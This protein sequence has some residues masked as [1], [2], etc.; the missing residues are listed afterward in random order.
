MANAFLTEVNVNVESEFKPPAHTGVKLQ[1]PGRGEK[2]LIF[3]EVRP[4]KFEPYSPGYAIFGAPKWHEKGKRSDG[5]GK[6]LKS[7][8]IHG[9]DVSALKIGKKNARPLAS[10]EETDD[11]PKQP[12]D[13]VSDLSRHSRHSSRYSGST[14]VMPPVSPGKTSYTGSSYSGSIASSSFCSTCCSECSC[15]V[16]PSQI[17]CSTC[18]EAARRHALAKARRRAKRRD[19]EVHF[20][21]IAA[22]TPQSQASSIASSVPYSAYENLTSVSQVPSNSSVSLS[23]RSESSAARVAQL[24]SELDQE[25]KQREATDR[26][27]AELQKRQDALLAKLREVTG[28]DEVTARSPQQSPL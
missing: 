1:N 10:E 17:S 6:H 4:R 5:Q 12:K 14:P 25:R 23:H 9:F 28:A 22:G 11:E 3:P 21:G 7:R 18:A 20:K 27:V 2:E 16:A 13:H 8:N 15:S 26:Q 19:L 24:Q